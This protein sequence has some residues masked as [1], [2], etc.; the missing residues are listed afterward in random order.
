MGVMSEPD[1]MSGMNCKDC[2]LLKSAGGAAVC[3]LE[4][5]P[6]DNTKEGWAPIVEWS[7]WCHQHWLGAG[8]EPLPSAPPCP[9]WIPQAPI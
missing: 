5:V 1:S 4:P 3:L 7:R 8:R 6:A 9:S 2:G